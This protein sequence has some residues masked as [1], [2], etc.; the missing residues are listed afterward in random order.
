M[1]SANT[2]V[3]T[4]CGDD[5]QTFVVIGKKP[6]FGYYHKLE[7]KLRI[8]NEDLG[9][10]IYCTV[11]GMDG[12]GRTMDN[13]VKLRAIYADYDK[14]VPPSWAIPPSI[15]V[16]SSPGKAQAYWLLTGEVETKV[17]RGVQRA[18]VHA[19]GGDP[20]AIDVSRILRVPGFINHKYGTKPVTKLLLCNSTRYLLNDIKNIY[21]CNELW[22]ESAQK[23]APKVVQ[24][25]DTRLKRYRAWLAA[26]QPP[27]AGNGERN[28]W[29][30]RKAAAGV[31]DFALP[32]AV[33]A[34]V[35][36]SLSLAAH[37]DYAYEY[38]ECYEIT[39]NA[40]R[41]A[42]GA[43]GSKVYQPSVVME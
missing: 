20:A 10:D 17:W 27:A 36:H 34:D 8:Y 37:G 5:P 25:D 24:E 41:S 42:T 18:V 7:T 2:F 9:K 12:K 38:D 35:L 28:G 30:Y 11:N 6:F 15:L 13:L 40:E 16:E 19:T 21:G 29:F 26:A 33:V 14:G 23:S 39:S 22:N 31:R 32:V 3:K 4:L 43:R 1:D